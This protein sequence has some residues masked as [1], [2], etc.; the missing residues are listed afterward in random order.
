MFLPVLQLQLSTYKCSNN[1]ANIQA[2]SQ[3]AKIILEG[4]GKIKI[5]SLAEGSGQTVW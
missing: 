1:K 5:E 2:L 3:L 4:K